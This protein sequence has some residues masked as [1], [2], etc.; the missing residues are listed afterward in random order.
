M[1]FA[2]T[3]SLCDM[4]LWVGPLRWRPGAGSRDWSRAEMDWDGRGIFQPWLSFW[5][6]AVAMSMSEF[7]AICGIKARVRLGLWG[8]SCS[9]TE[10]G[11]G[12]QHGG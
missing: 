11:S 7:K 5:V 10:K 2:H 1:R 4:W 6:A 9:V 3:V 8:Q 12:G